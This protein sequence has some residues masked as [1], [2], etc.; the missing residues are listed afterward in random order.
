MSQPETQVD[1]KPIGGE[2]QKKREEWE[3]NNKLNKSI[4]VGKIQYVEL[5]ANLDEGSELRMYYL[6]VFKIPST[7][8]AI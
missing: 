2:I 4:F 8:V 1:A 5:E 7:S 6:G 3:K